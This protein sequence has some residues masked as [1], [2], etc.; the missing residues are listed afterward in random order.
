MAKT[1]MMIGGPLDGLQV[2]N[3]GY[4]LEGKIV[5]IDTLECQNKDAKYSAESV[6]R[7]TNGKLVYD[8]KATKQRRLI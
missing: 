6:Y 4:F 7:V 1:I 5:A 8:A 2:P 3:D